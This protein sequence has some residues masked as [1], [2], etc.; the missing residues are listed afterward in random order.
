MIRVHSYARQRRDEGKMPAFVIEYNRR[1]G[2]HRV[3]PFNG[4]NGHRS[5]FQERLRLERDRVDPDMEIISLIGDSLDTIKQ[6]HSRYFMTDRAV[7][8]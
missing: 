6:T 5:A 4:R 8:V 3:T 1:T 2:A 7:G